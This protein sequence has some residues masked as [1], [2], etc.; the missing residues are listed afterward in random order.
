MF[1]EGNS[2]PCIHF[3]HIKGRQRVP[4]AVYANF[5]CI[6]KPINYQQ[7]DKTVRT[8]KHKSMSYR[9]YVEIDKSSIPE[10]LHLVQG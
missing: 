5:E 9:Y 2:L 6:L 4:L 1:E 7:T 10:S 8:H 3:T